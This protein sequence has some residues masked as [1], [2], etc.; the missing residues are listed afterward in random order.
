MARQTAVNLLP[1]PMTRLHRHRILP[2]EICGRRGSSSTNA[3]S[4]EGVNDLKGPIH[5]KLNCVK[6]VQE[7]LN[8]M[9]V[10]FHE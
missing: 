2:L 1:S 3:C 4:H 6:P 9:C 10:G 7:K 5:S 8:V